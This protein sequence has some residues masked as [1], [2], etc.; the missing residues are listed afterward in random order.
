MK[1]KLLMLVPAITVGIFL[2]LQPKST[3]VAS[4]KPSKRPSHSTPIGSIL[5]G[6]GADTLRFYLLGTYASVDTAIRNN[7]PTYT[8][9]EASGSVN[10]STGQCSI[11]IYHYPTF[12]FNYNYTGQF[13]GPE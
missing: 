10:I 11:T 7:P 8:E 4:V 2:L 9:Y 1:K 12:K 5:T 6:T 13:S 3:T